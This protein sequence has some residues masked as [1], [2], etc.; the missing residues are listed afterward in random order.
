VEHPPRHTGAGEHWSLI[1]FVR[2]VPSELSLYSVIYIVQAADHYWKER[3]DKQGPVNDDNQDWKASILIS[4]IPGL[5][6]DPSIERVGL[7]GTLL[8]FFFSFSFIKHLLIG[9]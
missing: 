5:V 9:Q 7:L 8:G 3:L 1:L 4:F 6:G 2:A